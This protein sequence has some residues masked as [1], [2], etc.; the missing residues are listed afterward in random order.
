MSDSPQQIAAK[1]SE[2]IATLEHIVA[3]L[4]ASYADSELCSDVELTEMRARVSALEAESAMLKRHAQTACRN[5]RRMIAENR[6][7]RA[8]VTAQLAVKA[9]NDHI[10]DPLRPVRAAYSFNGPLPA[11]EGFKGSWDTSDSKEPRR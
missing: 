5:A 11:S 4:S 2:R 6:A 1:K 8:K 3:R 9:I 10:A 7:F